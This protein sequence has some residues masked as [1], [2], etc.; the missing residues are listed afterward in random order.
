[1]PAGPFATPAPV[2]SLVDEFH[3]FGA[4]FVRLAGPLHVKKVIP[5]HTYAGVLPFQ[6]S[7]NLGDRDVLAVEVRD[8][9]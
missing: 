7:I 6:G 9:R 4:G 1:M 2:Q 8:P 5:I 3:E